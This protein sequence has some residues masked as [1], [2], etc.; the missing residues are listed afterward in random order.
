MGVTRVLRYGP[1]E[2]YA[3]EKRA[4]NIKGKGSFDCGCGNGCNSY[5]EN[6][7]LSLLAPKSNIKIVIMNAKEFFVWNVCPWVSFTQTILL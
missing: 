2:G 3:D 1:W 4:Y 6:G 7:N 5:N